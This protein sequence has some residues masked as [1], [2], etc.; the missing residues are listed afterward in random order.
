MSRNAIGKPLR[1]TVNDDKRPCDTKL[2]ARETLDKGVDEAWLQELLEMEPLLLPVTDI[3]ERIQEPLVSLG[4]EI[5]TTAGYIDNLYISQNGYL[6]VGETKLWRNQEARRKVVAQI[7]DYAT[8]LR[9]WD[10]SKLEEEWQNQTGITDSLWAYVH[11]EDHDDE[12]EWID[13]VNQNLSLGR[14]TLLIVG[15]GIR[16]EARQLT[17]A[18]SGHPDFQFRLGLVELRLYSLENGDVLAIPTL[19]ARTQEIQRAVVRIERTAE[20]RTDITIETP[21]ERTTTKPSVSVLTEEAF[22]DRVRKG[23]EDGER[24]VVIARRI[25]ELLKDTDVVIQWQRASFSVKY[26]DPRDNGN[27]ISL[28]YIYENG[29][30]G[31]WTSVFEQQIRRVFGDTE[32]GNRLSQDHVAGLRKLG[33]IGKKDIDVQLTELDGRE[34]D[35]VALVERTIDAIREEANKLPQ[36]E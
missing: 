13:L 33:A 1:V 32:T 4:C 34:T 6:V 16:S 19:L 10:Y 2:L 35:A 9:Q 24:N 21:T 8:Q 3:D 31:C 22:F 29:S 25:L 26:P 5:G 27:M 7:L 17:E 18:V 20:P 30:F 14:M 23:G 15:D 12:A 11:P 28:A 36:Q